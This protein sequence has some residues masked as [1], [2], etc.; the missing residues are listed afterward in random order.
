MAEVAAHGQAPAFGNGG[1]RLAVIHDGRLGPRHDPVLPVNT[2]S[3]SG[4]TWGRRP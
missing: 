1:G 3:A 2:L 4:T